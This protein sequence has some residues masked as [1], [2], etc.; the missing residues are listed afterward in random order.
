MEV[1]KGSKTFERS[2][3]TTRKGTQAHSGAEISAKNGKILGALIAP[4]LGRRRQ[5]HCFTLLLVLTI[6]WATMLTGVLA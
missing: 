2:E 4:R 5:R 6:I 3:Q 1:S